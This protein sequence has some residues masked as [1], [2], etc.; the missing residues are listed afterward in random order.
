M[1]KLTFKFLTVLLCTFFLLIQSCSEDQ[2]LLRSPTTEV[3]PSVEDYAAT[4]SVSCSP[5]GWCDENG[6]ANDVGSNG[7]GVLWIIGTSSTGGGFKIY[8]RDFNNDMWINVPGGGV[9][10]DVEYNGMPWIVNNANEIYRRN[11]AGAWIRMPGS[12]RDIGIGA[13]GDIW[14]IGTSSTGGGYKIYKWD[15]S[16]SNWRQSDGGGTR[17]SVDGSGIP[18]IINNANQG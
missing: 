1:K 10:I 3:I 4:N 17:I 8:F 2:E 14:I 12:A 9:A 13:N 15:P 16:I 5:S 6:L 18:W 7:N 11:T